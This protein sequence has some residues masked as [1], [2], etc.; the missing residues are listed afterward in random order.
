MNLR[1]AQLAMMDGKKICAKG[2]SEEYYSFMKDGTFVYHRIEGDIVP[3]SSFLTSGLNLY[4]KEEA[5]ILETEEFF[6]VSE[7]TRG[8]IISFPS[9]KKALEFINNNVGEYRIDKRYKT[10]KQEKK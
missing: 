2:Y 5:V 6:N 1:E 10:T 9:Y 4:V 3:I 8:M 7:K